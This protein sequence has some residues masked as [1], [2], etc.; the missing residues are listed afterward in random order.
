[1][2][3]LRADVEA[4]HVHRPTFPLSVRKSPGSSSGDGSR[5]PTAD[6]I[7]KSF[8]ASSAAGVIVDTETHVAADAA[9]PAP[10][11]SLASPR[12][13]RFNVPRVPPPTSPSF[14]LVGDDEK[15]DVGRFA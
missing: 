6:S 11:Y 3:N 10:S 12:S 15:V 13:P 4:E 8:G 1:M 2:L 14:M 5:L 9:S 7:S